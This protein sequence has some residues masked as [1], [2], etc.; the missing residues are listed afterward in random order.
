[1]NRKAAESFLDERPKA[2]TYQKFITTVHEPAGK[3]FAAG[4]DDAAMRIFIDAFDGPGAFDRLPAERRRT[5]MENARFFKALTLSSDPFPNLPKDAV[6]RLPLPV[7]IVRGA[8]TDELHRLVTEELGRVLPDARRAIIPHA[9]HGSPR[10]N[11]KAFNAALIDF[12]ARPST[13]ER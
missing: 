13:E 5:V 12:L 4:Q 9:G 3:V 7:L 8:D 6:R 11:A 1:L 2:P 10:Q